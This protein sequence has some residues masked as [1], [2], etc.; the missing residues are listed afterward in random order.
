MA[1]LLA[2]VDDPA[3]YLVKLRGAEVTDEG[4]S[5]QGAGVRDASTLFVTA[6]R[7]RPVR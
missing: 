4:Q 6:R 1:V 3:A 2:D 5:L 7:R